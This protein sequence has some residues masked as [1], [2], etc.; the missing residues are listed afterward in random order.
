MVVRLLRRSE[1]GSCHKGKRGDAGQQGILIFLH[2]F[3][4]LVRIP[5][6]RCSAYCRI[7]TMRCFAFISATAHVGMLTMRT[8]ADAESFGSL[9]YLFGIHS[10]AVVQCGDVRRF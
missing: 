2:P 3:T 8:Q 1:A 5:T 6:V 10:Q 4:P 7:P 9:G